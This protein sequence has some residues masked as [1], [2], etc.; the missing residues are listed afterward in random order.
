MKLCLPENASQE[1]K[2]I[3]K[4]Y[5]AEMV[6]SDPGEGSDGAIRLCRR[7][8]RGESG[9]LLSIRTSTTIRRTGKRISRRT[10]VEIMEQTERPDHAL[11]GLAGHQRNVH[12]CRR[13][14][15]R[16]ICRR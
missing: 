10:G 9:P 6:F 13:G 3:L 7:D 12:G 2:Q 8:L 5:G 15:L 4:A 1:R 14:G 16:K 11:C